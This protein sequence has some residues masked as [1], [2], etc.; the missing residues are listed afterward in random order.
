[1][2][3]YSFL[4]PLFPFLA[5]LII[6]FF[7][8]RTPEEG[9]YIAVGAVGLSFLT[10]I[11]VVASVV[12]GGQTAVIEGITWINEGIK[13]GLLVDQLTAVMLVVVSIVGLLIVIY[14]IGYMHEDDS[15]RRYYAEICL[16]IAS[17]FLLVISS[18]LLQ[19]FMSW[20]LV[21]LCSYL[22]IGFWHHKPEAR[23]AAI[24]AFLVTRLGDAFFLIGIFLIYAEL[25]TLNMVEIF[26]KAPLLK[27]TTFLGVDA[28]TVATLFLF[29]GAVGKSA[30]FPLHIWL[31]N[32]MEGPT[33]VS[34]LIHAAT[35]VKAGIYL[36]ARFFPVFSLSPTTMTVV[37]LIGGFT[38]LIAATMAIV[39]TDIKRIVA[40]STISHLGFMTLA[41]GAGGYAAGVF[42][43]LNHS[44]F[45]ALLF[46]ASGAIIHATHT[47]DIREM[48][49]LRHKMPLTFITAFI[50]AWS[51]SGFP[52]LSG[53][54]SKDAILAAVYTT[55]VLPPA[56]ARLAFLLGMSA[57]LMSGVYI[58]RWFF[59]IFFGEEGEKSHHAHEAPNVMT[60]PLVVLAIG[61]ALSWLVIF[62]DFEAWLSRALPIELV[63]HLEAAGEAKGGHGIV[64]AL[65]IAF[66]AIGVGTATAIYYKN[67]ISSS[68]IVARLKPLH[69]VIVNKYYMDNFYYYGIWYMAYFFTPT[70][71]QFD[72]LIIDGIVNF[73]GY[74][75][76][77][78]STRIIQPFNTIVIDK[79]IVD[80]AGYLTV[81]LALDNGE[82]DHDIV[83][84]S[85]NAISTVS[86]WA[87]RVFRLVQTGIIQN[88]AGA[89]IFGFSIIA[90]I[91]R[92]R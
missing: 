40:Y 67:M 41:L 28:A 69:T 77:F 84:G 33:T 19:M 57:A 86:F 13:F 2:L 60:Y 79:G 21:G 1:M 71:L 75:G 72:R 18:N 83:D 55:T 74:A 81:R 15:K 73:A 37:A 4:I 42:H 30:Q 54:W 43:L 29:G 91:I 68:T 27:T 3:E 70:I 35:M 34:A 64:V 58:F 63:E 23:S 8:K 39:M 49:G 45:K 20:E 85:I 53:F 47:N 51:L 7:G 10:S 26:E 82:F 11:A 36:V 90:I 16:F 59:V 66:A 56:A 31:P 76:T 62:G 46:L 48:G 92:M 22:L 17:M 88:Y 25:G 61:A 50:G 78:V 9:A 12:L 24:K 32:A 44:F 14:S 5:F 38:A 65:S 6:L 89:I 87:G 52:I 80:N